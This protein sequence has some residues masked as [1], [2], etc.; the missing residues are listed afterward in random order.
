MKKIGIMLM[1]VIMSLSLFGCGGS[2]EPVAEATTEAK[3]ETVIMDEDVNYKELLTSYQWVQENDNDH[4]MVF[5]ENNTGVNVQD[6]AITVSYDME[7]ENKN[8][9]KLSTPVASHF[10][11]V[12]VAKKGEQYQLVRSTDDGDI[13]YNATDI[14]EELVKDYSVRQ[15]GDT[16]DSGSAKFTLIEISSSPDVSMEYEKFGQ[17]AEFGKD[18]G[19]CLSPGEGNDLFINFK[20]KIENTG[21]EELKYIDLNCVVNYADGYSFEEKGYSTYNS[22]YGNDFAYD[23]LPVLSDPE[24]HYIN[25]GV[26]GKVWEDQESPLTFTVN[27]PDENNSYI[28]FTYMI[29]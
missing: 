14:P 20:V 24:E 19:S 29:R 12:K 11:E 28:P 26:P 15:I 3:L 6:K 8:L 17:P 21:K 4:Y 1:T 25:I 22:S 5:Y 9:A 23:S 27:L 18:E 10:T 7:S 16:V 2:S 13:I